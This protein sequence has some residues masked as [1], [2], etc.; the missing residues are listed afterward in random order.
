MKRRTGRPRRKINY[1][2]L[3]ALGARLHAWREMANLTQTEVAVGK[4]GVC[5]AVYS[6]YERGMRCPSPEV[7]AA[8]ERETKGFITVAEWLTVLESVEAA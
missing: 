5:Q 4:L 1:E 7:Q 2:R 3:R 6:D 8:I